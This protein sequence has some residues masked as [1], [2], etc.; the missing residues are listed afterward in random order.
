MRYRFPLYWSIHSILISMVGSGLSTAVIVPKMNASDCKPLFDSCSTL[1]P[2]GT[3]WQR[4]V[5]MLAWILLRRF[6]KKL[7][8]RAEAE[9]TFD[10]AA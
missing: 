7:P 4:R 8:E 6:S 10:R 1:S 2:L 9:R 5:F 3:V